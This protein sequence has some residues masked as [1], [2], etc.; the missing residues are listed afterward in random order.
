MVNV[1]GKMRA[2]SAGGSGGPGGQPAQGA[3]QQG[4]PTMDTTGLVPPG[5]LKKL[6]S[7]GPPKGQRAAQPDDDEEVQSG[8]LA[9]T[10]PAQGAY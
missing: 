7:K 4:L 9:T 6:R 3:P 1:L 2:Q 8:L 10:P 5:S